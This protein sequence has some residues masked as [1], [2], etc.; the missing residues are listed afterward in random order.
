MWCANTL[1]Q[2]SQLEPLVQYTETSFCSS[3]VTWW[4]MKCQTP[5]LWRIP[6]FTSVFPVFNSVSWWHTVPVSLEAVLW[7]LWQRVEGRFTPWR[8]GNKATNEKSE[9]NGSVSHC[10]LP[11]WHPRWSHLR[12]G[13]WL[14]SVGT[15][16]PLPFQFSP[17]DLRTKVD[18]Q[19]CISRNF[20][21]F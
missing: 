4:F 2:S 15:S 21:L 20:F 6:A 10:A 5:C 17:V 9:Q 7:A 18:S 14:C 12:G 19:F 11:L 16:P 8:K 1:S 13:G 3:G